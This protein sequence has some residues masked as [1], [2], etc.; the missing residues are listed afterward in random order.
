MILKDEGEGK[1]GRSPFPAERMNVERGRM[2]PGVRLL[3][4][5]PSLSLTSGR[6]LDSGVRPREAGS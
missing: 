5:S 3:L 6:S 1:C 2:T 4:K